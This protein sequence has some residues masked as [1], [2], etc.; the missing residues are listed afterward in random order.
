[1][2]L[3]PLRS[4]FWTLSASIGLSIS[5]LAISSI[6]SHTQTPP[7]VSLATG[8]HSLTA[9]PT[10]NPLSIADSDKL[11]Y[12][13]GDRS[14]W[15]PDGPGHAPDGITRNTLP[16][17]AA[18]GSSN[19]PAESVGPLVPTPV[20]IP[21]S[22]RIPVNVVSHPESSPLAIG[23]D[24]VLQPASG[25]GAFFELPP[26]PEF[27]IGTV[28][29]PQTSTPQT[30]TAVEKLI[31]RLQQRFDGLDNELEGLHDEFDDLHSRFAE[32]L[33]TVQSS[34]ND[35]RAAISELVEV[36]VEHE[37]IPPPLRFDMTVLL[38]P[39]RGAARDGGLTLISR[40][41][42]EISLSIGP[43]IAEGTRW[44]TSRTSTDTLDV[45]LRNRAHARF[46]RHSE[47]H[48]EQHSDIEIDL[49][50]PIGRA[51]IQARGSQIRE[52]II[53]LPWDGALAMRASTKSSGLINVE[54]RVRSSELTGADDH[55]KHATL[56]PDGTLILTVV[57]DEI[58][59]PL[60]DDSSGRIDSESNQ[61]VPRRTSTTELIVLFQPHML[62]TPA[63]APPINSHGQTPFPPG[64]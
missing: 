14:E 58:Y 9:A 48:V 21:D 63:A 47:L 28:E 53:A 12:S 18:I 29:N 3:S 54:L 38:M 6:F 24:E 39:L 62:T 26:P 41:S 27:W 13:S 19:D 31:A 61:A 4:A 2:P 50:Q 57:L 11:P 32:E 49:S 46:Q 8:D 35:V 23:F 45:W 40:E 60:N 30:N 59:R 17:V 36:T 10:H 55:W 42:P 33:A 7:P 34:H 15:S 5:L 56:M 16:G 1:M 64:E 52:R 44:A 43:K 22:P 25:R 51:M 37:Q 20:D